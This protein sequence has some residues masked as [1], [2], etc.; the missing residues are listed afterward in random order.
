MILIQQIVR[1]KRLFPYHS[2]GIIQETNLRTTPSSCLVTTL[3]THFQE[4]IQRDIHQDDDN[5]MDNA[6]PHKD[7]ES[8]ASDQNLQLWLAQDYGA[9]VWLMSVADT[10]LFCKSH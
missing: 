8:P 2:E 6:E 9:H 7:K 10:T 1:L 5:G 3:S 4:A